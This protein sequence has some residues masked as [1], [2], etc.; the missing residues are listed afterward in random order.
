M[1]NTFCNKQSQPSQRLADKRRE[2]CRCRQR[3]C[4]RFRSYETLQ[5]SRSNTLH[6]LTKSVS[7]VFSTLPRIAS[8]TL[9]SLNMRH[10]PDEIILHII[11]CE[12]FSQNN[13]I[14]AQLKIV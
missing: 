13:A 1:A 3:L 4:P 6:Y 9:T 10:L 12:T 7:P 14:A 8:F 11:A 2:S 5:D